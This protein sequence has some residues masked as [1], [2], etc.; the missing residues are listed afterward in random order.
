VFATGTNGATGADSITPTPIR[1]SS[2]TRAG[3]IARRVPAPAP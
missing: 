3:L 2:P 1:S